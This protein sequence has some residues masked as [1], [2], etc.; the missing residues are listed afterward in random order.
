MTAPEISVLLPVRDAAATLGAALES[1]RRQSFRDF[2]CIVADDGSVD[3]SRDVAA[4][5]AARDPRFTLLA[6]PRRGIVETLNDGLA[7][8][9]GRLIARMDADDV[10]A[11]L[12]LEAERATLVADPSLAATG[13]HV[14]TFPRG[15]M[16]EGRLRYERWLNSLASADDVHRDRF[17]E[18]PVA[19]PTLVARS[20]VLRRY[21][22]R[23]AGWA[24]DY[25]LVLR[26]LG[27]GERVGVTPRR[28][29]LWRDGPKRHSREHPRYAANTFFECKAEFLA[30]SFLARASTYVLWGYG[31]TGRT[32]ARALSARAKRPTHI[33]EIHPRRIGARIFGADVISPSALL[34]LPSPR[35]PVVVSVAGAEAR[36]IIRAFFAAHDI[37]EDSA[38]VFAA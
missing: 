8:C 17:V 16:A 10:S 7:A 14:R 33:V 29:L 36:A 15:A 9:R 12:R 1:I 35:P 2:E 20:E 24:E 30:A 5:A 32:L 34:E 31:D 21:G 37:R 38:Y 27:D 22:Y 26:L 6:L 4:S 13:C 11:R 3:A 28:L 23:D 25:D 19:H 18:C